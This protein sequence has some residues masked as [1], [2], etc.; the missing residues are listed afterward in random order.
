MLNEPT[1]RYLKNIEVKATQLEKVSSACHPY[2][3]LGKLISLPPV[4]YGELFPLFNCIN[5]ETT[6]W[7]NLRCKFCPSSVLERP[8]QFMEDNLYQ[9]IIDNLARLGYREQVKLY[10]SNEPL[11]DPKL[12]EKIAY[13][14]EKLPKASLGLSTNAIL[15]TEERLEKLYLAGL[16]FIAS[17]AYLSKDQF[18]KLRTLYMKF[19]E[20]HEGI[21]VNAQG[22][23]GYS[24]AIENSQY[25]RKNRLYITLSKRYSDPMDPSSMSYNTSQITS[26]CGLII[27][28]RKLTKAHA[29][30]RPSRTMQVNF[31][32]TVL[33][34]CEEWTHDPRAIM[35]SLKLNTIE[36]IWNGKPFFKLRAKLQAGDRSG[37]PCSACNYGGGIFLQNIRRVEI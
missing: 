16:N 29:C 11:L 28:T 15:L 30:A 31:D 14:R 5:I 19:A 8:H 2:P 35:G 37:Y 24:Y 3:K 33:S 21:I 27:S 1:A 12:E 20:T 9:K 32:G 10:Q 6:S 18:E 34:C 25:T 4:R 26:R 23:E 22:S 17:E 13:A 36:E 7:C